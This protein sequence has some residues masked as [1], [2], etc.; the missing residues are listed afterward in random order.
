M[1]AGVRGEKGNFHMERI[2][3]LL[4][5]Y[6]DEE[7]VGILAEALCHGVLVSNLA[8]DLAKELGF[9]EDFC[10]QAAVA[11]MVHDIGKLKMGQYVSGH[12]DRLMIED[13]RYTKTHPTLGYLIV[14]DQDYE[15]EVAQAVLHHHENYDGSGYPDNLK[16]EAIPILAR[17]LRPCDFFAAMV[18][19]RAYRGAFSIESALDMMIEEVKNFDM[20][21]FL[22]FQRLTMNDDFAIIR[23]QIRE[24]NEDHRL[25]AGKLSQRMDSL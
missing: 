19:E 1:I 20:R 9:D 18:S 7:W 17:L 22:A 10:H 16:G 4:A 6:R 23:E 15:P 21:I 12:Q 13:L 8:Y 11:G 3:T 14:T 5:Q 2:G 25:F 24:V